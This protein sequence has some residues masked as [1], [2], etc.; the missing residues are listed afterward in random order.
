MSPSK[1]PPKPKIVSA[2]Q[3]NEFYT[4]EQCFIRELS[5]TDSHAD[6]SVALARVEPGITTA[7]HR[8]KGTTER[9]LVISGTGLVELENV[10]PKQVVS[11][12]LVEIPANCLQRITNTGDRDLLFY[13]VC[14]PRFKPSNYLS[15]Q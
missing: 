7:W 9:Y 14:T 2:S 6:L 10:E 1:K 13:A 15:N 12:D 5:N 4:E 8:L 3:V 11:G